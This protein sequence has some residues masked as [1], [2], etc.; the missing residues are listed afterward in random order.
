MA[1]KVG[2][3]SMDLFPVELLLGEMVW[4][5]A[6]PVVIQFIL[7]LQAA[8]CCRLFEIGLGPDHTLPDDAWP[9]ARCPFAI[10]DLTLGQIVRR[11]FQVYV[12]SNDRSDA[13]FAHLAGHRSN[14]LVLV[15]DRHGRHF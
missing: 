15:I 10:D 14:N 1:E 9:L 4:R 12:S 8:M 2:C 7:S 6:A 13:K 11:H 5:L 3:R